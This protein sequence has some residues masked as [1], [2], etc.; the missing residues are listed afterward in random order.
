MA[1]TQV[2][3]GFNLLTRWRYRK[4]PGPA[5]SWLYGNLKDLVRLGNHAAYMDW[6]RV[7]GPVYKACTYLLSSLACSGRALQCTCL[8]FLCTSC[9]ILDPDVVHLAKNGC[10]VTSCRVL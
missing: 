7:H 2:V 3:Y 6:H 8:S 1:L 9:S 10:I 4:L 5:P